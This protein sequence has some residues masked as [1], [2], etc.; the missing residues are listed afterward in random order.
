MSWNE[1]AVRLYERLG[2]VHEGRR[3]DFFWH[4]GKYH[5]SVEMSMLEQEW[6]EMYD[7]KKGRVEVR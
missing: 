5:D 4:D 6:R 2:F 3:R 1:G 7:G